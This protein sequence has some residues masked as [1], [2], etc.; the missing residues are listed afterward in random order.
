MHVQATLEG[1]EP[2]VL[3]TSA[4]GVATLTLNRPQRFNPQAKQGAYT[5][6]ETSEEDPPPEHVDRH[7]DRVIVGHRR[8]EDAA[9][10]PHDDPAEPEADGAGRQVGASSW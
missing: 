10:R 6:S 7:G 5:R 2:F 4:N 1:Q 8:A 9:G 3:T